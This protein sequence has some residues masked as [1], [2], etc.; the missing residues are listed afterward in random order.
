MTPARAILQRTRRPL[1]LLAAALAIALILGMG[2]QYL[3]DSLRMNLENKKTELDGQRGT[4]AQR[5]LD[6]N[7]IQIHIREYRTLRQEGLVGKADREG[8]VEQL[9]ESRL[10][11][12]LG[13]LGFSYTLD[14]PHALGET[15]NDAALP[16]DPNAPHRHDLQIEMQNL[17]EVELLNLLRDYKAK[18][19]GQFRIESCQLNGPT[20]TGLTARCTLRFFNLPDTTNPS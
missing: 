9:M 11:L 16:D 4:M 14:P 17:H 3:L 5:Q 7:N 10:S 6:L 8:W 19:D 20:P 15:T 13:S 12:G 1:Y 2:S 18:V